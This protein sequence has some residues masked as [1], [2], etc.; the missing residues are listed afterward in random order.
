MSSFYSQEELREIGLKRYGE[1]VLISRMCSIYQADKISIGSNVR[2][3]DFCILSGKIDIG[4]YVHIAAYVSLF[5][6]D[7]G[8]KVDDFSGVSSK[9]AVYAVS[10][11]YTG[12]SMTNPMVPDKYKPY[13]IC[14]EVKIGKHAIVGCNSVILPGVEIGVGTAIGSMSL[15]TKTTEEW[16]IYTGIPAKKRGVRKRDLLELEKEFWKDLNA[17]E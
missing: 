2:I 9:C 17:N 8:I 7:A 4:N 14:K 10:D 13:L 16:S 3:D 6:G 11:D 1:N 5:A 15:C 12:K